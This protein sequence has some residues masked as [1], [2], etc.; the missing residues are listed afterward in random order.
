MY[1]VSFNRVLWPLFDFDIKEYM[2]SAGELR[3]KTFQRKL[4][5]RRNSVKN[6]MERIFLHFHREITKQKNFSFL[7]QW[8]LVEK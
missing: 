8:Q 4:L 2:S 3:K 5:I 7:S 6:C 1:I